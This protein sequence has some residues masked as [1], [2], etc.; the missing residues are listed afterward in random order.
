MH[1]QT[2]GSFEFRKPIST[3]KS[4]RL[5]ISYD[6]SIFT[7]QFCVTAGVDIKIDTSIRKRSTRRSGTCLRPLS[8]SR[9]GRLG[10]AAGVRSEAEK[11]P[12]RTVPRHLA[13]SVPCSGRACSC[14]VPPVYLSILGSQPDLFVRRQ[15][16]V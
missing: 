15:Q 10:I 12:G 7:N 6:I 16:Y 5:R 9:N 4:T 14:G 8:K 2:Y 1:M 11:P 3:S 13:G